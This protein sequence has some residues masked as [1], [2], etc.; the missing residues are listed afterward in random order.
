MYLSLYGDDTHKVIGLMYHHDY[1]KHLYG[2]VCAY[3][4]A[5]PINAVIISTCSPSQCTYGHL[6][7]S[8][9]VDRTRRLPVESSLVHSQ[10]KLVWRNHQPCTEDVVV[11]G[12]GAHL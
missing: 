3:M 7:H 6:V 9:K 4:H 12:R 2:T 8:L 11:V 5:I 10:H 1:H